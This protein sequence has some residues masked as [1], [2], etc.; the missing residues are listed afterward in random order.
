[1]VTPDVQK[2]MSIKHPLLKLRSASWMGR[3]DAGDAKADAKEPSWEL[4]QL[5]R[6]VI[7]AAIEVH[8]TLGPGFLEAIYEAARLASRLDATHRL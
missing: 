2:I 4:D 8:R 6:S 3:Q 7:G 1:M 5:A